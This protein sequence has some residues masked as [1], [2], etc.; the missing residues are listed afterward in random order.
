MSHLTPL[1]AHDEPG[2]VALMEGL[3]AQARMVRQHVALPASLA[4]LTIQLEEGLE[5]HA[6]LISADD[7]LAGAEVA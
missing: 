3:A 2:F 1:S 6:A 7:V 5:T 4:R